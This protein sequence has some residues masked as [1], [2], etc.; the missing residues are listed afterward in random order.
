MIAGMHVP[1]VSVLHR[2][3]VGL[4]LLTLAALGAG[5]FFVANP[6][7]LGT[8]AVFAFLA[9]PACG[10]GWGRG[11][12]Q[13]R[14][15]TFFLV[16]IAGSQAWLAGWASA[17]EVS[18]RLLT[19]VLCATL[20]TFTTPLSALMETLER[21]LAPL[22]PLGVHPQALAFALTLTIRFI[23][24]LM[25]L[26]QETRE[27]MAARGRERAWFAMAVPLVIRALRMADQVAEAVEARGLDAVIE[28]RSDSHPNGRL[29][30]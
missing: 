22:R 14:A 8:C 4:K 3:P 23:P 27:A 30:G 13:I 2:A 17:A 28:G 24:V 16:L 11:W 1:G 19:L 18:A 15:L 6:W 29:D 20:V 25:G 26:A 12:A 5:L 10:L 9:Y 7:I 21:T